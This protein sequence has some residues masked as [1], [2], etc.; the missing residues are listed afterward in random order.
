MS[1]DCANGV[2]KM[3]VEEKRAEGDGDGATSA[4]TEDIVD[5]WNVESSSDSGVDYDKLISKY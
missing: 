5:P 4:E 1:E 3:N 2:E